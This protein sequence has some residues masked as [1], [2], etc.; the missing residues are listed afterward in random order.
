MEDTDPPRRHGQLR[1]EAADWFAIMRDPE[2]AQIKRKDFEAWLARGALH[3][4]AY[5]R[6]AEAYSIGKRLKELPEDAAVT[7]NETLDVDTRQNRF[8]TKAAKYALLLIG[9]LG[10]TALVAHWA[11]SAPIHDEPTTH[12]A[13]K[14]ASRSSNQAIA[15]LVTATGGIQSFHLKDG[16]VITL[17]TNSL[18][19]VNFDDIQR[20]LRLLRGR[21]RFTVAHE[22]RPFMVHAGRGKVV[23]R[24]TIFDVDLLPG[25]HVVVRLVRGAVDVEIESAARAA[26]LQRPVQLIPGE[27][28]ELE[29]D[30][31]AVPT[32]IREVDLSDSDW[33]NGLRNFT[34]VRLGDLFAEA[35]RYASIPLVSEA[36]DIEDIRVSGSFRISDSARLARNLGDMLGLIVM[37]SPSSIHLARNCHTPS[38][39]NCRTPS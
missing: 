33:P 28:V 9:L 20:N 6:I 37:S 17:D 12:F 25:N 8:G 36:P 7:I 21:A 16:S 24:G 23:A 2:E 4:A 10:A 32:K 31:I 11:R 1:E 19:L 35:N 15:T 39:G 30:T 22:R 34:N 13:T 14:D 29:N 3:R 27:Q 18:V 5:N 38:K 26:H